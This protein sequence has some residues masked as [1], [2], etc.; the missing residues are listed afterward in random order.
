MRPRRGVLIWIAAIGVSLIACTSTAP[1]QEP[2]AQSVASTTSAPTPLAAVTTSVEAVAT[3]SLT[4]T[5]PS[6]DDPPDVTPLTAETEAV[7]VRLPLAGEN[8]WWIDRH[9]GPGR[10]VEADP[11]TGAITREIWIESMI[12]SDSSGD[13]LICADP[14]RPGELVTLSWEFRGPTKEILH[15]R[16]E[17]D[18]TLIDETEAAVDGTSVPAELQ[19]ICG[20][21]RLPPLRVTALQLSALLDIAGFTNITGDH[22]IDPTWAAAATW[23]GTEYWPINLY[24]GDFRPVPDDETELL[25]CRLG[26]LEVTTSLPSDA[27]SA[28]IQNAGC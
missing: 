3:S 5:L 2:S 18:G 9:D 26:A 23:N 1:I 12:D 13:T 17:V 24:Q 11:E 27:R 6:V 14:E 21:P 25:E 4:E 7:P 10:V 20:E 22:A 28:L 16:R 8:M 15:Q 19:L